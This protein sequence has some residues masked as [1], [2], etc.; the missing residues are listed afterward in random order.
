MSHLVPIWPILPK[1]DTRDSYHLRLPVGWDFL[2]D[3]GVRFRPDWNQIGK[4]WDFQYQMFVHF[5]SLSQNE[6]TADLKK[7]QICPL[8]CQS[9]TIRGQFGHPW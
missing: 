5:G 2:R 6:Q 4:I 8:W 9:G 3:R 7:S 1:Y